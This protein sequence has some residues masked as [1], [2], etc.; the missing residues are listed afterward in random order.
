M[1][2][3]LSYF[4]GVCGLEITVVIGSDDVFCFE[5][6]MWRDGIFQV[7][8]F[9]VWVEIEYECYAVKSIPLAI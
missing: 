3:G 9:V 7:V 2:F 8:S 6:L 4:S 5:W 1:Y